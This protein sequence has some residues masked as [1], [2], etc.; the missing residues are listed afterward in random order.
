MFGYPRSVLG[1]FTQ[2]TLKEMTGLY[3]AGLIHILFNLGCNLGSKEVRNLLFYK[4]MIA[5]SP[6]YVKSI[7]SG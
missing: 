4:K 7:A 6:Y 2:R 5:Q 1:G 3:Y